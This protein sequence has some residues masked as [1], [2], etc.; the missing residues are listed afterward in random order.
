MDE[1]IYDILGID[2]LEHIGTHLF[3]KESFQPTIE[4][5]RKYKGRPAC[6]TV[7]FG[8]H[9]GFQMTDEL[10]EDIETWIHEISE[11]TTA[12]MLTQMTGKH[13]LKWKIT[14]KFGE[15]I[16]VT[17]TIP[18]LLSSLITHSG[19][20]DGNDFRMIQPDEYER[21]VFPD[22]D[23]VPEIDTVR[24]TLYENTVQSRIGDYL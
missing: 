18:H 23:K 11:H 12:N 20:Y 2:R 4:K 14:H 24:E 17:P 9:T 1:M 19:I 10:V 3:P 15:D 22:I 13:G 7:Y 8:T 5:L 21:M 16:I 6:T